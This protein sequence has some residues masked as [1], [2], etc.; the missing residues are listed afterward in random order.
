MYTLKTSLTQ[1]CFCQLF[2]HIWAHCKQPRRYLWCGSSHRHQECPKNNEASKPKFLNCDTP[3]PSSYRRVI[4]PQRDSQGQQWTQ[5]HPGPQ[6]PTGRSTVQL[7]SSSPQGR[8]TSRRHQ[9]LLH[10]PP[11]PK[12]QHP[13]TNNAS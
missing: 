10:Q 4:A 7:P 12:P 1:C 6:I 5:E 2:G 9:Y 11:T 3:H 8:H 13:R